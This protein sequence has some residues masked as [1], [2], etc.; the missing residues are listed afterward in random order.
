MNFR[1]RKKVQVHV[2]T[3]A[4][5]DIMFFLML[6]FLIAST[7]ANPNVIKLLLP[8]AKAGQTVSKQQFSLTVSKDL[9]YYINQDKNPLTFNQLEPKLN[10]LVSSNSDITFVLKIDKT[11][12]VQNLVDVLALGSKLKIKMILATQ[13]PK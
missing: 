3:S 2:E 1:N 10:A 13:A 6:F 8:Q 12:Q 5:S 4:L 11:V 9:N 7:L